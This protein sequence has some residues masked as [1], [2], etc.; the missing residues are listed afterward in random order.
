MEKTGFALA[1][2][3]IRISSKNAALVSKE[4]QYPL[5]ERR[6]RRTRQ[7]LIDAATE[8]FY[9][10]G[11]EQVTLE[12]VAEL[13]EV[14]VQTLYRHFPTKE[15]LALAPQVES[16]EE[17]RD[18][19]CDPERSV[20]TFTL[21]RAWMR[22]YSPSAKDRFGEIPRKRALEREEIA[23][24]TVANLRLWHDYEDVFTSA[25]AKDMGVDPDTDRRPRLIACMLWGGHQHAIRIWANS[26]GESDIKK[27]S[28]AV[29]DEAARLVAMDAEM[30]SQG[31][32]RK[33]PPKRKVPPAKR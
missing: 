29:V 14:H 1:T 13:A 32:K 22:R 25:L 11:Y 8:L 6:K 16:F 5:R 20:D 15:A 10:K 23:P 27:E 9:T 19:L 24:L 31:A 3:Q 26:G 33:S 18:L 28:L 12:E 17:F 30:V 4:V 21:W 7:A 2:D